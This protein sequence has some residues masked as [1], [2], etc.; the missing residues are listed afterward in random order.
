MI[1]AYKDIKETIVSRLRLDYP[2]T[3]NLE[4]LM[5]I[6]GKLVLPDGYCHLPAWQQVSVDC[7]AVS[8]AAAIQK[9][10]VKAVN[11]FDLK[12][13]I[14]APHPAWLHAVAR[15]VIKQGKLSI[16]PG[17]DTRAIIQVIEKY[18]ILWMIDG[19]PPYNLDVL[20]AWTD[21]VH[22]KK[23]GL[24]P[25]LYSHYFE[26]FL[27]VAMRLPELVVVDLPNRAEVVSV[28]NAGGTVVIES[29]MPFEPVELPDRRKIVT[30]SKRHWERHTTYITDIDN[31]FRHNTDK[32]A[33]ARW[34][35]WG[36]GGQNGEYISKHET[37]PSGMAWQS[38]ELLDLE[39]KK[40]KAVAFGFLILT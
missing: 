30:I 4:M 1:K 13:P 11:Y 20:N 25:L 36:D 24:S 29:D 40:Y 15:N 18:G 2:M 31:N 33:V 8:V 38:N 32:V 5:R 16:R 10:F 7:S 3:W 34:Q 9:L 6:S 22:Y 17:C 39:F 28:L 12:Y 19:I 35:I 37:D 26:K 14:L 23:A 21:S 27:P